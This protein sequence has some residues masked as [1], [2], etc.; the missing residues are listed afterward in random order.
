[1]H[2]L[3]DNPRKARF[4]S[5]KKEKKKKRKVGGITTIQT[6]QQALDKAVFCHWHHSLA[7]FK[8]ILLSE[9]ER[10]VNQCFMKP[11]LVKHAKREK[12]KKK[13]N[14]FPQVVGE[15]QT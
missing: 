10:K 6:I 5:Q 14:S 4:M 8:S 1:M 3:G 15:S 7:L 2:M 13:K 9:N 12:K 11:L